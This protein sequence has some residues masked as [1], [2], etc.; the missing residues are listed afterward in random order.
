AI[1]RGHEA[2]FWSSLAALRLAPCSGASRSLRAAGRS[3]RCSAGWR[4]LRNLGPPCAR[5]GWGR[6][7]RLAQGTTRRW[8]M[9]RIYD[10]MIE[11]LRGLGPVA[12]AIERSDRD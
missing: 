3:R 11:V 5:R 1:A 12:A 8:A 9:L 7:L 10:V 2:W 6:V 4:P